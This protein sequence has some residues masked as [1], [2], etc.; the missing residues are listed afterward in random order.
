[1]FTFCRFPFTVNWYT[2]AKQLM[3]PE[4]RIVDD[5][6]TEQ[7]SVRDTLSHKLGIPYY[8]GPWWYGLDPNKTR[9]DYC[10]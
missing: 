4:F 5:L 1:M 8:D 10:M 7:T 6:R 3:G 9:E 2:K